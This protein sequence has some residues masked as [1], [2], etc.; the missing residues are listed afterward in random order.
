MSDVI[1]DGDRGT[2]RY[3]CGALWEGLWDMGIE[4]RTESAAA[5]G[6]V[7]INCLSRVETE[8]GE[9]LMRE[10]KL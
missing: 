8:A 6:R 7:L 5:N 10:A 2:V 1:V 4:V 9:K 3:S